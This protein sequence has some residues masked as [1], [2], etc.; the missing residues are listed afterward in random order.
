MSF[1]G[2]ARQVR[3]PNLPLGQRFRALRSA[4][5]QYRRLG[6]NAT[7]AF[8]TG[9][10]RISPLDESGMLAA[11]DTVETSRAA[12]L[13]EM[14]A[15]GARRK[16]A[17]RASRTPVDPDEVEYRFGLRWP[18]PSAHAAM[19]IAVAERWNRM[20]SQAGMRPIQ[21][22]L[23]A[24]V[25]VYLGGR[26]GAADRERL[27]T[28]I[29]RMRA[30]EFGGRDNLRR[31][32]GA[33]ELRQVGTLIRND[34]LPL[35]RRGWIGDADRIAEVFWA[36]RSGMPYLPALHTYEQTAWW[37]RE[38][39]IPQSE[40]WIAETHGVPVGFAALRGDW[41]DHLYVEPA[42][43]SLGIGEALIAKAKSRQGELHLWV[44]EQNTGARAFYARHGFALV[45][46]GDGSGNEERL[47]DMH[48]RW[49]HS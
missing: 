40:L 1:N 42:S 22:E 27:R 31:R 47:P 18:G 6:F 3:D 37:V 16:A 21:A 46:T 36:A 39:M 35:V 12:W 13:V 25:D 38:V 19:R 28:L 41:L 48:L 4:V 49:R 9:D 10:T 14:E 23:G 15:F 44:F 30:A 5:E 7:W 26:L 20:R 43:Q 34:V 24:I 8:I 45:E 33:A 17:K 11:L 29:E 32:S 2:L